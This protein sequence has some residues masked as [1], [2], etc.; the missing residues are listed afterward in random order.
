MSIPPPSTW[1]QQARD[2]ARDLL[3]ALVAVLFFIIF[4]VQPVRVEGTSMQPQLEDQERIFVSKISYRVFDIQRGDV[5]VFY[6]PGDPSKSFIKRVVGLPGETIQ[7]IEGDVYIN[8]RSISEKY[9]PP[10]FRDHSSFGPVIV[11]TNCYF[12][13]GDHRNVSNDSR[14]WGCVPAGSIFGKAVLKY[15][16]PTDIGLVH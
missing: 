3:L 4:L 14:H 7:I 13:M 5:V 9:I 15:W 6:F 11:P 12:V 1:S 8:G 2:A 10:A 16:P